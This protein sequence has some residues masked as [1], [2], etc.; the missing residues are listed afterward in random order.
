M[1]Y[2]ISLLILALAA[3]AFATIDVSGEGTAK[4]ADQARALAVADAHTKAIK[5]AYAVGRLCGR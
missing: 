1:T 5:L 3:P 4:T 2:P